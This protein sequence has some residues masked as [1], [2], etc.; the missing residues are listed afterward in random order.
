MTQTTFFIGDSIDFP[1]VRSLF[2]LNNVNG[3]LR[4][5]VSG[6]YDMRVEFGVDTNSNGNVDKYV[7]RSDMTSADWSN[8]SA[9]RIHLLFYSDA[10]DNVMPENITGLPFANGTFDAPDGRMYQAFTTTIVARNRMN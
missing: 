5:I 6:V 8:S 4:E 1:G 9:V 3:T 10:L 7:L 2:R